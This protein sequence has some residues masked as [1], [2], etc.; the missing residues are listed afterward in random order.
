MRRLGGSWRER[1]LAG[2]SCCFLGTIMLSLSARLCHGSSNPYLLLKSSLVRVPVYR[3]GVSRKKIQEPLNTFLESKHLSSQMSFIEVPTSQA[4][5]CL[6][7]SSRSF[8]NCAAMTA[9]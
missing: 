5:P 8:L 6:C 9:S 4:R 1:H 7:C 2:L 3:A